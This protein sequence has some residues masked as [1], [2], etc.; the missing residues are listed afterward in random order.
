MA[1]SI[2]ERYNDC[3]MFHLFN[4]N[5]NIDINK[6]STAKRIFSVVDD[7]FLPVIK[8]LIKTLPQFITEI[9]DTEYPLDECES[10]LKKLKSIILSID[11]II[12][13][14]G[15]FKMDSRDIIIFDSLKKIKSFVQIAITKFDDYIDVIESRKNIKGGHTYSLEAAFGV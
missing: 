7:N 8:D 11:A 13:L 9:E 15:S 10:Q 6:F 3:Q 4:S 2:S 12:Q 14:M 1:T 5:E